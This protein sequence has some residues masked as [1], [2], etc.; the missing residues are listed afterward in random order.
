MVKPLLSKLWKPGMVLTLACGTLSAQPPPLVNPPQPA[1]VPEHLARAR[2]LAGNKPFAT[3]VATKGY[4]CMP[5]AE[6]RASAFAAARS[7]E[8]VPPVQVFDNLYYI[9]KVFVGVYIL[10]T[11]DGLVMWD[12]LDN[13]TEVRTILLPGMKQLHLNPAE[14]KLII[15]THGHFDHFGGAKYMQDTY[16]TPVAES[17]ADWDLM[18]AYKSDGTD[19]H[20]APPRKDRVLTDGEKVKVGDA[21]IRIVITPG[22]SPGTVSS[23][24]PVKDKGVTRYMAMWGGTAYPATMAALDQ[25]GDSM[26]KFKKAAQEAHATGLLNDH[27]EFFDIRERLADRSPNGPNPLVIGLPDVQ[28]SLDVM[29]E[30]LASMKDWYTAMGKNSR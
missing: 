4:W 9:G 15:L 12:A 1:S 22:H 7:P 28:A 19:A 10:K 11:S 30:C 27:T 6:G 23:I 5:P 24:L 17:E 2:Q 14:I 16:H 18:A 20:P 26:Q 25:M 29:S 13:P 21:T 3:W 8:G